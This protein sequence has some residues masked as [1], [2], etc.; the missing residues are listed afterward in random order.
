MSLIEAF[1]AKLDGE[2]GLLAALTTTQ[3]QIDEDGTDIGV[4]R[5]ALHETIAAIE[6]L[7]LAL[8]EAPALQPRAE[9]WRPISEA[10]RDG[11][12]LAA[13]ADGRMM[14]WRAD[15]LRTAMAQSTPDHLTF[16]ATHFRPLPPPPKPEVEG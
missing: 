5:Q 14:I 3:R 16:P 7:R 1:F 9:E 13:T 15:L 12:F 11:M 8:S 10:P 6:A 4:S 2:F